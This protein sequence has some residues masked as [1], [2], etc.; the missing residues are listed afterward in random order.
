MCARAH[1]CLLSSSFRA[2]EGFDNLCPLKLFQ[3]VR[4]VWPGYTISGTKETHLP[5][6]MS[7]DQQRTYKDSSAWSGLGQHSKRSERNETTKRRGYVE[8]RNA[9]FCCPDYLQPICKPVANSHVRKVYGW[10]KALHQM[11]GGSL[12]APRLE[13]HNS[14]GMVNHRSKFT[15]YDWWPIQNWPKDF[16]VPT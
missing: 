9:L 15:W 3:P 4:P 14:F 1:T 16:W 5:Q 6:L 8:I 10:Y 13:V 7:T 2:F 12:V 11:F